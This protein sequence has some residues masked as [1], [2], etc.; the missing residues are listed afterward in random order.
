[1]QRQFSRWAFP[2]S[3]TTRFDM[4]SSRISVLRPLSKAQ[5]FA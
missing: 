5:V 2:P 1:M 4:T 3:V